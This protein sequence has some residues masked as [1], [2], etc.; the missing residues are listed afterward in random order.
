MQPRANELTAVESRN[1]FDDVPGAVDNAA[2]INRW[3]QFRAEYHRAQRLEDVGDFPL[4]IDFELN[5][6]CQMKC[7]FCLHGQQKVAKEQIGFHTFK[8]IIDD[9]DGLCSIK[10]NDTNEPLLNRDLPKFAEYARSR[11]V[12][13]V[14][15]ATN[16]LLL[17]KD[18]ARQLIEAKVSKIMISLDA[19][20]PETFEVMRHNKQFNK[21]VSNILGLLEVRE[22]M[23]VDYPLVRVNFL[24]T[25]LNAHEA[26]DFK[27]QWDGIAD[28]VGYQ[29][30]VAVP[31]MDYQ[32]PEKKDFRCSMPFKMVAIQANGDLHPCCTFAGRLM[33]LGNIKTMT[34]KEAWNS[35]QMRDLRELHRSGNYEQNPICKECI[36]GC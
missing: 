3:H 14:Y 34:I 29:V 10:L 33:T 16:G 2:D 17:S 12:L 20:T 26:E 13:N 23:G 22:E 27:K 36:N 4:Q 24:K 1:R 28:M 7:S 35:K 11:G 8:R 9:A 15:F 6:S 30:Q 5:S 19:T 31:G 32:L 21:I 25:E 18:V